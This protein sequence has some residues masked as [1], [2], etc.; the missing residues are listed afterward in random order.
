MQK[1]YD[2]ENIFAKIIRGEV[3]S[4]KVY[5]DNK[6]LA[7]NDINPKAPI[8][9]LVIPKGEFVSF[10]DFVEKSSAEDVSY[11]FKTVQKIAREQGLSGNDY[12]IVGNCGEK[13]G[14]IVFHFHIHIMGY[15]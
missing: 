7:F 4:T 14:Q 2:K 3:P 6:I 15:K 12:R 11:F 8:H 9:I 5:E 1:K 13:A 10:D